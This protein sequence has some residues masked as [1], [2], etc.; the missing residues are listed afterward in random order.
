MRHISNP[1][2][3]RNNVVDKLAVNMQTLR[4]AQNLEKGIYNWTIQEATKR[5]TVKKWENTFFVEIYVTRLR[6]ILANIKNTD[7][8]NKL[9]SKEIRP[10]LIAFMSHQEWAPFKWSALL[11]EKRVRDEN[12]YAP[13]LEASTDNF[14]CGKCKSTKC[15]YYQLQTRSS[16]EP[17]TCFVNCLSCGASWK[18]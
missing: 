12:K 9:I 13:K 14:T 15:T 5:K 6:S 4:D 10:H 11:E 18:C 2:V 1:Q 7:L 3:F 17:M 8:Q 16:D